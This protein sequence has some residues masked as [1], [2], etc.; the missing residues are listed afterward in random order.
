MIQ[1]NDDIGLNSTTQLPRRDFYHLP[2][3]CNNSPEKE[4]SALV[5]DITLQRD[6][7]LNLGERKNKQGRTL[8]LPWALSLKSFSPVVH[9]D[10]KSSFLITQGERGSNIRAGL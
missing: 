2:G 4:P 6:K 9:Y 1:N 8:S 5:Q 10:S 7:F 3:C